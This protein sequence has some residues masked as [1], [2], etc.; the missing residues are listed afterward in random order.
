MTTIHWLFAGA[1]SYIFHWGT[2]A[3]LIILCLAGAWFTPPWLPFISKVDFLY[4]AAGI[5]VFMGAYTLG[6][7][8]EKKIWLAREIVLQQQIEDAV[9]NSG[10]KKDPFDD[11]RN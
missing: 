3:G 1:G 7:H 5:A 8:D 11:P 10:G 9:A 6:A 2:A 4:A